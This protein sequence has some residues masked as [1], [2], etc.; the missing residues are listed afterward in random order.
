MKRV[1]LFGGTFDPPHRGHSALAR[2]ALRELKLDRLYVVPA[3]EPPLKPSASLPPLRRLALARRA[4]GRL[5]RTVVSPWE[6]RRRGP[7]YTYKT[8]E[9]FRRRHPGARWFLVMGGD[10][11]GNFR[12]WKRWRGILSM[13]TLAVG[14]RR[15]SPPG[16]ID[17]AIKNGSLLLKASLPRI[18][19]TVLRRRGPGR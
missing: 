17:P 9:A 7:S 18:S 1:G 4:F 14:R 5:P 2:A 11:W 3:G 12:R 6:I 15:G 8:L 19:S 16:R 10:S 13:A